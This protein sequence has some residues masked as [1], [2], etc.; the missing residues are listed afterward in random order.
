MIFSH[1][2]QVFRVSGLLPCSLWPSLHL[3]RPRF[4]TLNKFWSEKKEKLLPRLH[5]FLPFF[6]NCVDVAL[7]L[8]LSLSLHNSSVVRGKGGEKHRKAIQSRSIFAISASF[9][10]SL[11]AN[12]RGAID[13]TVRSWPP[14]EILNLFS[15]PIIDRLNSARFDLVSSLS[16]LGLLRFSFLSNFIC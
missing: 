15:Q 6:F 7:S 13:F 16:D 11:F 12:A 8:S 14:E 3:L 5:F 9:L 4:E 2:N 10:D 1:F